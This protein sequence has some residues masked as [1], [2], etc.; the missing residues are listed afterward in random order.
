[1]KTKILFLIGLSALSVLS[2]CSKFTD[3][4]I[5]GQETQENFFNAGSNA[6][7]AVNS[8]YDNLKASEGIYGSGHCYD[9]MFSNML[10]DDGAKGSSAGDIVELAEMKKWLA[11][12]ANTMTSSLWKICYNS[13]YRCNTVLKNLPNS[14]VDDNL[15]KRLIAEVKFLRAYYYFYLVKAFGPVPLFTEP[16]QQGQFHSVRSSIAD[17]YKQ[18]DADLTEA[19]ADLPEKGAYANTELGRA[20]KGAAKAYLA[21][22]IMYQLGTDYTNYQDRAKGWQKVYDLCAEIQTSG[23]YTLAPNYA[24]IFE[25]EGENGTES[26]FEVQCSENPNQDYGTG[27]WGTT[28]SIFTNPRGDWGGWGFDDPTPSLVSEYE[29]NDVRLKC[30]VISDGDICYGLKMT[31]SLDESDNTGHYNRKMLW[32]PA[33]TKPKTSLKES[34]INIRQFR[35]ADILLMKAEAA[36]NLTKE[37]EARQLVNQIR[38]RARNSTMTKGSKLGQDD[39]ALPSW[40]PATSLPAISSSV[41]GAALQQAIWHERRVELGMEFTRYMDLVRT[42]RYLSSLPADVAAR[43]LTHCYDY[44]GNKIPV[45]PINVD[46]SNGWINDDPSTGIMKQNPGY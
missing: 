26:I 25:N 13:L 36:Y 2:S 44:K 1:M 34:G 22:S 40:D 8:C 42:G 24:T 30:T 29:A 41:T 33:V 37:D 9:F 4:Q 45:L 5:L 43:C 28:T 27:K 7:Y 46:E 15:K 10:S 32:D 17:V 19:A 23:Q 3:T 35:Y 20:T 21:R 12:S 14:S 31:V 38:E 16:V 11:N 39:Y 18:I 6:V